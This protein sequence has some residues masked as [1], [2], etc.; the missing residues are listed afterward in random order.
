MASTLLS[1][2]YLEGAG[3][4]RSALNSIGYLFTVRNVQPQSMQSIQCQV[5]ND[6]QRF[7]SSQPADVKFEG[8]L[9]KELGVCLSP[10]SKSFRLKV[11]SLS[12]PTDSSNLS[13]PRSTSLCD[14]F[15]ASAIT[16]KKLK[17]LGALA[18][19]KTSPRT[20]LKNLLRAK[21]PSCSI[22][23]TQYNLIWPNLR[24][25]FSLKSRTTIPR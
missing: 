18:R 3:E 5:N 21:Y 9:P 11:V 24:L 13:V 7:D 14:L 6:S 22:V 20:G 8:P 1:Q 12:A 16:I 10:W 4:I 17:S 19:R 2:A 25:Q 23:P 15:K